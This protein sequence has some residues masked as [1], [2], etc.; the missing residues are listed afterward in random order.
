MS[1]DLWCGWNRTEYVDSSNIVASP[2]KAITY[3]QVSFS[4]FFLI[5][6]ISFFMSMGLI[7]RR[8]KLF[9][10]RLNFFKNYE[11]SKNSYTFWLKFYIFPYTLFLLLVI[12]FF[13]QFWNMTNVMKLLLYV[14]FNCKS[15][16]EENS[17]NNRQ[18]FFS[19]DIVFLLNPLEKFLEFEV[20]SLSLSLFVSRKK[21]ENKDRRRKRE[22]GHDY[23]H[24]SWRNFVEE[25]FRLDGDPSALFHVFCI[26]DR[27]CVHAHGT[28]VCVRV[29]ACVG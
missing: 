8:E 28:L 29:G 4:F 27:K 18:L 7:T 24:R 5:R 20:T 17:H 26:R 25:E 19:L 11:N 14:Y 21:E 3:I 9:T 13:F 15:I 6:W 1:W 23:I 12:Y 2:E 22:R 16:R 10:F